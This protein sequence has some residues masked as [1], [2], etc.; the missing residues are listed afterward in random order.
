MKLK[1]GK[2]TSRELAQWMNI[3]Y[4]T[5]RNSI[6]KYLSIVEDYCDFEKVYGGIIVKE[7][8]IEEYDK[9]LSLKDEKIYLKEIE[10]CIA[11]QDGLSTVAGMSRKLVKEGTFDSFETAKRRMSK[12]GKKLFGKTDESLF[13]HGEKG[14][15]TYVWGVKLNDYNQYRRLTKEEEEKFDKIIADFYS[16]NV[17]KVKKEALLTDRLRN[18]EITVDEYFESKDALGVDNFLS[19]IFLFK[20][21]TGFLITKCSEHELVECQDFVEDKGFDF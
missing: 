15:R 14:R 7:I 3:S 1:I 13:S 2:M 19:C 18:K 5:Y 4:N 6:D 9:S 16:A 21:Q 8:Y 11:E 12:T 10:R 17:N 20:E